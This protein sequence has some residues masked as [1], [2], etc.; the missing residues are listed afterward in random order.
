VGCLSQVNETLGMRLRTRK[1]DHALLAVSSSENPRAKRMNSSSDILRQRVRSSSSSSFDSIA[2]DIAGL[3]GQR[4]GGYCTVLTQSF[5]RRIGSWKR[6]LE[7]GLQPSLCVFGL[8]PIFFVESI[9]FRVKFVSQAN[10]CRGRIVGFC[11]EQE[12]RTVVELPKG[13]Q[14]ACALK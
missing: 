11:F 12:Q 8:L 9:K 7:R 1:R 10:D 14:F 13:S 6:G 4:W 5:I 2:T 3:P